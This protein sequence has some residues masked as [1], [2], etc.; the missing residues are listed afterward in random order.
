MGRDRVAID[1]QGWMRV[2]CE[3]AKGSDERWWLGHDIMKKAAPE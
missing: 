2:C 3:E 1:I